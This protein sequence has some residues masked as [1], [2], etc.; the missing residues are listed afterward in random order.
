MSHVPNSRSIEIIHD[1]K[2]PYRPW[3]AVDYRTRVPVLRL[4]H[5]DQLL[6]ICLRFGW[7]VADRPNTR[8]R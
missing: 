7:R 8:P 4:A 5:R 1:L 2:D 6:E 3:V